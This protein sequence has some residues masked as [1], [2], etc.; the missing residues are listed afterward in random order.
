MGK[1]KTLDEAD[2]Q[3]YVEDPSIVNPYLRKF[4]P[5]KKS[6]FSHVVSSDKSGHV[7]R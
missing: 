3:K 7:R 5:R 6:Q 4:G 1:A 2:L